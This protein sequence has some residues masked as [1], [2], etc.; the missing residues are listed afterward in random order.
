MDT[1]ES[2]P[3][4]SSHDVTIVLASHGSASPALH[5]AH[6]MLGVVQQLALAVDAPQ[7][8]VLTHGMVSLSGGMASSASGGA[9]GF[10]RVLRLEQPTVGSQI[11]DTSCDPSVMS[12][13]ALSERSPDPE[14]VL[15]GKMRLFGRLRECLRGSTLE[16]A[17]V[18]G[19]HAI[20]G[21]LGGLGLCAASMLCEAGANKVRR[22]PRFNS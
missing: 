19:R 13:R 11:T 22:C 2:Q 12:I 20:T 6:L 21:G 17:C 15:R 3:L 5:G 14:T 18:H 7:L 4:R 8:R 1:S 16:A 10:G 9:W